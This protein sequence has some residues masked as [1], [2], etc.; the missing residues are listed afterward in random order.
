MLTNK[1]LLTG[2]PGIGKTTA[3][4]RIVNICRTRG[5]KVG[6]MV[7]VEVRVGGVR[8]G[9][10]IIDVASGREGVLARVGSGLRPRIGKYVVNIGDLERVGVTAVLNAL[11]SADLV[12]IDEIGPMELYSERFKNAVKRVFS[13]DRKAVATLHIRGRRYPIVRRLIEEGVPVITITV[14][15]R[16]RVPEEVFRQLFG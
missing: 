8:R 10:K 6:G 13:S 3:V 7:T 14:E 5:I 15:N 9:F 4:L 2:R 12:V 16:R 11:D 1:V